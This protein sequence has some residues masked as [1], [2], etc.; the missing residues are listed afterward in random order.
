L[1]YK[2]YL[3]WSKSKEQITVE[4]AI[5]KCGSIHNKN[6]VYKMAKAQND[7]LLGVWSYHCELNPTVVIWAQ[8]EGYVAT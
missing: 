6:V 8:V 4:G 7:T 1:E 5:S 2:K 3:K